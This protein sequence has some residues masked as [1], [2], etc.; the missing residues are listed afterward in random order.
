MVR[1]R[2]MKIRRLAHEA[3]ELGTAAAPAYLDEDREMLI[4]AAKLSDAA[5]R[6]VE[7]VE[8]HEFRKREHQEAVAR[9]EKA[10][11]GMT[12]EEK[13]AYRRAEYE[14]VTGRKW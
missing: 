10:E 2:I 4:I 6:A 1:S 14:R 7:D 5:A 9:Q 11:A 3:Y 12:E 8:H 13:Q